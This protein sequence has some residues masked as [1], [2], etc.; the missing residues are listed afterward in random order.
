MENLGK[1]VGQ[2]YF[3]DGRAGGKETHVIILPAF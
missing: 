1:T 2:R 3:T